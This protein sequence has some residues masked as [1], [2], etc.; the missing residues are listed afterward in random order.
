MKVAILAGGLGT[1]LTEE[2]S[3]RP[4]PM[5]EIGGRPIL[6]HIMKIYERHGFNDFVILGGYKVEVI[7]QY[8][9]TYRQNS[10]DFT[11]DLQSGEIR[12][13]RSTTEK[14]RVTILDTGIN[15][16]TGG[17]IKRAREELGGGTFCLTYGDGVS[18]IDLGALVAFHKRKGLAATVTAVVPPGRFGF[19]GLS[20]DRE[21][22]DAF[23]EKDRQDV[24]LIN[25]GFFV[26]EPS[27]FDLIDGDLTVWEREPMER[28]AQ[29]GQLA[30][31]V[32]SGY[33]QNMDTLRDKS[34]LEEA[35]EKGA[36]WLAA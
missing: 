33:W 8:F 7:K 21:T 36:P 11:I 9:A 27:V 14:W 10:D 16:M 24:G 22:V 15:S 1:R 18:D 17:R 19:L 12:W 2:T 20:K 13:K 25:G 29:S 35:Y 32:H 26:C 34:V 23:R 31:Y 6:W 30:A 5:V 4:K 3:V 28:L